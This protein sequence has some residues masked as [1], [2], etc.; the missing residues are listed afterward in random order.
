V[1]VLIPLFLFQADLRRIV[2]E[3]SR[4]T[5]AFLVATTGT[6]A[7][8]VVAASLLDLSTLAA[9]AGIP[10]DRVEAAIAGLFAST[11]IGGSVNYAALGEVTGLR[12]DASFFSAATAA[13][14][15]F[16]AVYL[17]ILA[18]IPATHWIAKYFRTHEMA[19]DTPETSAAENHQHEAPVS[20]MSLCLALAAAVGLVAV[21][22]GLVA[23]FGLDGWRYVLLTA[24]SV[25]LATLLPDTR[26]WFSGAFEIG[27][28]LSFPFFA[29]IAAGADVPAMLGVA[30][31]LI[32]VVLIL[33]TTHLIVLLG[34]GAVFRLT[35]P[36][37]VTASNAAILGATTAPAL[38]AAKGWKDQVTPGVLVGVLGYALGTFIGTTLFNLW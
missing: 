22:D 3:A 1:P 10:A 20:P 8:V 17:S 26:R 11:Y 12:N 32:A 13:D 28:A 2:R 23:A 36:E 33:L 9:N 29:S 14:N 6:V 35:L 27:V 19:D 18:L 34:V 15:L 16:S 24:L 5:L 38:A 30:P 7:G 37:L 4:T 25:A 31:M 21:T